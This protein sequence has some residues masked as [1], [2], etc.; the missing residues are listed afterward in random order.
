M[1]QIN[2]HLQQAQRDL[3]R[4][5]NA[6]ESTALSH[7]EKK[8][9]PTSQHLSQMSHEGVELG[10][11]LAGGEGEPL[12]QA[13][14]AAGI[15]QIGS[16][17]GIDYIG[18]KGEPPTADV[19]KVRLLWEMLRKRGWT[20]EQFAAGLDRFLASVRFATWT[21]ADFF[22]GEEKAEGKVRVYPYSWY[23][24][25]LQAN[26][27]NSEA[28]G[29]YRVEGY[30]KPVWGWRHEV[31]DRLP[32]WE[33]R[34]AAPQLPAGNPRTQ[35]N[36][37]D[38]AQGVPTV[39]AA[40][41]GELLDRMRLQAQLEAAKGEANRY[42]RDLLQ[43]GR[44]MEQLAEANEQ[45]QR[46]FDEYA[47]VACDREDVLSMDLLEREDRV[48]IL[49]MALAAVL[50]ALEEDREAARAGATAVDPEL[51]TPEINRL[52]TVLDESDATER[53]A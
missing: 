41:G 46:A 11:V 52:H 45:I 50:Q 5:T 28:I 47:I 44:K 22:G 32:E 2:Q 27:L 13:V 1:D 37:S 21:P 48:T 12:S 40:A 23:M 34:P 8:T 3:R 33:W 25:Q 15:A 10:L 7:S 53:G 6:V 29:V 19:L 20:D 35:D 51:W 49:E 17:F 26:R 9:T 36:G 4:T 24:E 18:R 38:T 30:D 16:I 39:N 42:R 14:F 43:L 31:G